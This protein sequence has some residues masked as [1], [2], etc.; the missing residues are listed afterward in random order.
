VEIVPYSAA[1]REAVDR[2]NVKLS[3]A[4]SEWH[5]PPQERPLDA[6]ALPVWIESFVAAE[7]SDV[8]GGYILKHQEFFVHGRPIELGDL[9][10]PLS[11]GQ[12]DSAFAHVSAALLIDLLRRS[13]SA[14]ALGLGSEETQ[15]AK[16]LGA[17]GWRHFTV[18]FYFSVKSPNRFARNI[19]LPA[20]KARMEKLLRL[21]GRVRLAGVALRLRQAVARKSGDRAPRGTYDRVRVVPRFDRF[22][23]E[24]F[25]AHGGGY[26]LVGDRRAAALNC[27]YPK[28]DERYIRL[29]VERNDEVIGWAVVLDTAMRD[30]KYF[31]QMRVGSLADCFADPEAA[32]SVVA[33]ADDFLTQRGVDIAVSNQFHP[34]WC[35]ALEAANYETG[36]S[37]FFFYSSEDLAGQLEAVPDWKRKAHLNRGDGEGPA[38]L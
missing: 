37:N 1:H 35:S 31:G 6:D 33:A 7:G 11:V 32:R 16:L 21:L 34:A 28:D 17:A 12:V 36:P 13:P 22:A 8:Y 3:E 30:H 10:L 19:R 38:N 18:P 9:Q 24:L 5:F 14:Y 23:D 15:F 25:A 26:S 4:G 20:D 27:I 2:M 29:M